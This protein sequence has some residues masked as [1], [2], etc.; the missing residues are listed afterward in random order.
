VSGGGPFNTD[1]LPFFLSTH[2]DLSAMT[3]MYIAVKIREPV[4][5]D[6]NLT[7]KLSR[8]LH[9]PEEIT[10]MEYDILIALQWKVNG[11]TTLQFVN[12]ILELLPPSAESIAPVLYAHSHFQTELA[13]GD[14]AFVPNLR[15][16][17]IAL[18]SILNSLG[19]VEKDGGTPLDECIQ[20]VR[21]ISNSFDLDIDSPT[22]HAIRGRLLKS[23]S[24]CSKVYKSNNLKLPNGC[25]RRYSSL[26][27]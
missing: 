26:I 3:C 4:V 15:Q 8:G 21:S 18:A 23:F 25:Q 24:E 12:Y 22:V 20:F 9:T 14:Y 17:T 19:V 7:S 13:V 1:C 10:A 16:S 27:G 11:P 2:Y 5:L 6:A